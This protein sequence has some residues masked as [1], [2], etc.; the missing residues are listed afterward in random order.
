MKKIVMTLAAAIAVT[1]VF[2]ADLTKSTA[3]QSI[4]LTLAPVI[5]ITPSSATAATESFTS[6]ADYDGNG[7]NFGTTTW[8]VKSNMAYSIY[9]AVASG[10]ASGAIG[11]VSSNFAYT[12]TATGDETRM[13]L[14]LLKL[15]VNSSSTGITGETNFA[16]AT[17][18]SSISPDTRTSA[19][20]ASGR[21]G[22]NT[23][24]TSYN[25]KPGWNYAAGAYS[26]NVT[27]TATQQ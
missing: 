1:S 22:V 15:Q 9:G 10:A 6:V 20:V 27:L 23:M 12:G 19:K 25:L 8:T 3:S 4:N 18:G 26:A 7:K 5:E 17:G 13:P 21:I 14:S 11:A 2:A 24:I 16:A